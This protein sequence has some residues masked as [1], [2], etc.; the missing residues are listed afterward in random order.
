M[1]D[2]LPAPGVRRAAGV[3]RVID[4]GSV[5]PLRSQTLWHA[6]AHGV[7]EGSPPTLSFVRSRG[8]YACLGYHRGFDELDSARCRRSGLPIYR[9]MVGGGPVYVDQSQLCFQISLPAAMV[10]ATRPQA[11]RVLLEPA[12]PAFRSAGVEADLDPDLEIVAGDRKVCGHGAGQFGSGVTVVGNLIERFDHSAAAS[13]LKT[14]G[15]G[16]A[17]EVLRLMRRYV[18]WD[19]ESAP[20]IDCDAF[21]AGTRHSYSRALGLDE[22]DGDLNERE[23]EILERLDRRFV[24]PRWVTR[25]HTRPGRAWRLKVRSGVWLCSLAEGPYDVSVSVVKGCIERLRVACRNGDEPEPDPDEIRNAAEGR[26]LGEAAQRLSGRGLAG[27]RVA[28]ALRAIE[29]EAV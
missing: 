14:P 3:L 18:A 22:R 4:F 11:L 9:R 25:E 12:L 6:V 17:A 8:P 10:P 1:P 7:G 28:A 21:I 29:G 19:G 5:S 13:M 27:G 2:T 26:S 20:A 23:M 16:D 15:P 24:D